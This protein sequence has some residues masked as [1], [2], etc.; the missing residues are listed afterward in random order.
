MKNFEKT[1]SIRLKE[2]FIC[3]GKHFASYDAVE[4]YCETRRFRINNTTT[5]G[6]NTFLVDVTSN[7]KENQV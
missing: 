3:N 2:K 4:T 7:K 6:K 1:K 5:I